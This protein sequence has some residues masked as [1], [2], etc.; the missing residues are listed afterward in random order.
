[1]KEDL[2]ELLKRYEFNRTEPETLVQL[3]DKAIEKGGE[4]RQ[5][6]V[7]LRDAAK[8]LLDK[9][10]E[11]EF[12]QVLEIATPNAVTSKTAGGV[13][14]SFMPVGGAGGKWYVPLSCATVIFSSGITSTPRV[15]VESGI[16][17]VH[18]TESL[19]PAALAACKEMA[20]ETKA[21][22]RFGSRFRNSLLFVD[23]PVVDPPFY[24]DPDYVRLRCSAFKTALQNGNSVLGCA[25]RVR[26]TCFLRFASEAFPEASVQLSKFPTDLQLMLFIFSEMWRNPGCQNKV[27]VTRPIDVTQLGPDIYQLYQEEGLIVWSVF[28]QLNRHSSMCRFDIPAIHAT[29]NL[30]PHLQDIVNFVGGW[31]YPGQ[32]I[33]LPIFLADEKCR[34]RTGCAQVLYEEIMTRT[35]TADP[36]DQ[37][38]L[39]QLR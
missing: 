39:T 2:Y 13:D 15:E 36:L 8:R 11:N 26:D 18:E 28:V 20:L 27:L 29:Q 37:I 4:A 10:V 22:L 9:F 12:V 35:S 21:I 31:S 32:H 33:P 30:E 7:L 23:G 38:V 5:E 16:E 17:I 3:V 34:I 1:M 14:G 25:K 19:N 24:K 6:L